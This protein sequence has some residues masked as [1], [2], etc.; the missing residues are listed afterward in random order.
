MEQLRNGW[1]TQRHDLLG[2]LLS[3]RFLSMELVG[4]VLLPLLCIISGSGFVIG[5]AKPVPFNPNLLKN[6]RWGP[7]LV[8][9]AGY[10]LPILFRCRCRYCV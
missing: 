5:W 10:Q 4:S 6:K 8:A 7:A 3:I 9:V 2:V 1:E